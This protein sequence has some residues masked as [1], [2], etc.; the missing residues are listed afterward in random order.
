MKCEV[1][2]GS[3]YVQVL[4]GYGSGCANCLGIG[5]AK[6]MSVLACYDCG[7]WIDTD[8]DPASY[9][10]DKGKWLCLQ[11]RE[12]LDAYESWADQKAKEC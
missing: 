9:Q 1:C 12:D 6:S 10:E 5:E 2:D 8:D 11:C 4:P 7:R 3:G